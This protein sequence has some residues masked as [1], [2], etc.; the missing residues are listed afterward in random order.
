MQFRPRSF[1]GA[2]NLALS[3][4]YAKPD[5]PSNASPWLG[6][7]PHRGEANASP[8]PRPSSLR[9]ELSK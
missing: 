6:V 5:W 4:S 3:P 9:E 7:I 2:K 8:L 1:A